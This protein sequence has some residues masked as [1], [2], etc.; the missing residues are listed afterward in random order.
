MRVRWQAAIGEVDASSIEELAA[1][2]HRD[3]HR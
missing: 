1:G 2:G 3:E